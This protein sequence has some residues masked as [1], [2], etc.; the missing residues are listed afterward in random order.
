MAKWIMNDDDGFDG[1]KMD[2]ILEFKVNLLHHTL[3][4]LFLFIF[5]VL[6]FLENISP[7]AKSGPPLTQATSAPNDQELLNLFTKIKVCYNDQ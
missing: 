4:F 2:N 5:F 6:D 1:I 7:T 3:R